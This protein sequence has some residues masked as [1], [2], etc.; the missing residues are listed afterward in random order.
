MGAPARCAATVRR[1]LALLCAGLHT[2]RALVGNW[3]EGLGQDG[4][5]G[6]VLEIIYRTIRLG[7]GEQ[8]VHGV[9]QALGLGLG[10]HG[11]EGLVASSVPWGQDD[12]GTLASAPGRPANLKGNLK[13][14]HPKTKQLR[15][16]YRVAHLTVYG[17]ILALCQILG[18]PIH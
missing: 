10:Q 3:K 1:G 7:Q 11:G 5:A 16:S 4:L 17:A 13:L 9:H 6:L 15:T 2:H 12:A 18:C 8:V 14:A